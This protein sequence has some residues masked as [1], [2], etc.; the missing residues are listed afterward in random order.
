MFVFDFVVSFGV[1]CCFPFF[2]LFCFRYLFIVVSLPLLSLCQYF[3]PFF[4]FF[5]D[6]FRCIFCLAFVRSISV[7]LCSCFMHLS[8]LVPS[9]SWPSFCFLPGLAE[10]PSS[11]LKQSSVLKSGTVNQNLFRSKTGLR[12][13]YLVHRRRTRTNRSPRLFSSIKQN[14]YFES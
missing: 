10:T 7:L 1:S 11:H 14:V 13:T 8:V 9:S 6:C 2:H 12:A 5:R 4:H 3:F